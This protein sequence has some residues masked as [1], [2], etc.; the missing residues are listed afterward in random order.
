MHTYSLKVTSCILGDFPPWIGGLDLFLLQKEGFL[1]AQHVRLAF[2]AP[3]YA[4]PLHPARRGRRSS[5]KPQQVL[6]VVQAGGPHSQDDLT[7]LAAAAEQAHDP[8][9]LTLAWEV[10]APRVSARYPKLSKSH[11]LHSEPPAFSWQN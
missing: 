8:S 1:T 5:V 6:L 9:L 3:S 7:A 11:C 2:T 10:S 4:E